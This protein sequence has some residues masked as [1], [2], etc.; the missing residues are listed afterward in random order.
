M[1]LVVDWFCVPWQH[2]GEFSGW[3]FSKGTSGSRPPISIHFWGFDPPVSPLQHVQLRGP[4]LC[5]G[6]RV[7]M[8]WK[9][10]FWKGTTGRRKKHELVVFCKWWQID[11]IGSAMLFPMNAFAALSA[12]VTSCLRPWSSRPWLFCRTSE[13]CWKWVHSAHFRF[14][15]STTLCRQIPRCKAVDIFAAK[16][17]TN[18]N[19]MKSKFTHLPSLSSS[20]FFF[21]SMYSRSLYE[22]ILTFSKTKMQR[23]HVCT[24]LCTSIGVSFLVC[25][26]PWI[27]ERLDFRVHGSVQTGPSLQQLKDYE[28]SCG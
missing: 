22:E 14:W 27:Q 2:W 20:R 13:T 9:P 19:R 26:V 25:T 23:E 16:H 28:A 1:F 17:F 8:F 24:Q 18:E 5:F 7:S 6:R 3:V 11:R 4:S 10:K 12:E 15:G 21:T